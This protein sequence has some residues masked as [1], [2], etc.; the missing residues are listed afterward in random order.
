MHFIADDLQ[1]PQR[2]PRLPLVQ[3]D[4][5]PALLP[6][7]SQ[8]PGQNLNSLDAVASPPAG[9]SLDRAAAQEGSPLHPQADPE[10]AVSVRNLAGAE[11]A[12]K[13]GSDQRSFVTLNKIFPNRAEF[14]NLGDKN[15]NSVF[16]LK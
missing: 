9:T 12:R 7:A 5:L 4:L 10:V 11:A 6:P 13:V 1:R 14:S 15:S 3:R 2:R 8:I 16:Q